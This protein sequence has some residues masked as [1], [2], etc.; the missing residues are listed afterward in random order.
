MTALSD[1]PARPGVPLWVR[2]ERWEFW[3][4]WPTD[5]RMDTRGHS[6][7]A[8]GD[9]WTWTK[10]T[11]TSYHVLATVGC[12]LCRLAL[13]GTPVRRRG[14][15]RHLP[16]G[17]VIERLP[18]DLP[19]IPRTTR[20]TWRARQKQAELV[21]DSAPK[22]PQSAPQSRVEKLV[23]AGAKLIT[24]ERNGKTVISAHPD[25]AIR[26]KLAS[27]D[28]DDLADIPSFEVGRRLPVW[29]CMQ[30]GQTLVYGDR[31][32]GTWCAREHREQERADRWER[33]GLI[34]ARYHFE[35]VLYR[36]PR[37]DRL[38]AWTPPASQIRR[39]SRY[40]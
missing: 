1:L 37:R 8:C 11:R 7:L 15:P 4:A 5:E 16:E 35:D 9:D 40:R 17:P 13:E 24:Y 23:A 3:H 14:R 30:C 33:N 6:R 36:R 32:C 26:A 18:S 21:E 38:M 34:A 10:T 22:E 29:E 39:A 25:K 20:P 31:F 12:Y 2:D 28:T 27:D 19:P